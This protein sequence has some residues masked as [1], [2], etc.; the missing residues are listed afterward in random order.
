MVPP[1]VDDRLRAQADAAIPHG[2]H[3][4]AAAEVT[5]V[6]ETNLQTVLPDGKICSLPQTWGNPRKERDQNLQSVEA[7]S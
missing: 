2:P 5:V 3:L 7:E 4:S 1:V 6:I